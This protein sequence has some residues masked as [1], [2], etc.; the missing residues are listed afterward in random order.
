[1]V[2][3]FSYI[4]SFFDR[5]DCFIEFE[6]LPALS[7]KESNFFINKITLIYLRSAK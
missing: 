2:V 6:N 3:P 4:H 1:M 7:Q 5:Y